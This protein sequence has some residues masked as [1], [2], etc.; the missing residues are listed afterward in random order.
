MLTARDKFEES[1]ACKQWSMIY[2]GFETYFLTIRD[3]AVY[4]FNNKWQES[5]SR[6]LIL[7]TLKQKI[8]SLL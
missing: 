5:V 1:I 7:D 4:I 3:G 2:P 8:F 6:N